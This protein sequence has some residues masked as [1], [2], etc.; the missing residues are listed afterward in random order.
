V[1]GLVSRDGQERDQRRFVAIPVVPRASAIPRVVGISVDAEAAAL[2]DGARQ[3]EA[4]DG[5]PRRRRQE[6]AEHSEEPGGIT[7]P[8]AIERAF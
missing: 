4:G 8:Q 5:A 6:V 7:Q 2:D 3:I 1:I